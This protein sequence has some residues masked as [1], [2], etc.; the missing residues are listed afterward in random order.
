VVFL[1]GT[2]RGTLVQSCSYVVLAIL[3]LEFLHPGGT[4][5]GSVAQFA[6]YAAILG[7]VFWVGRVALTA[8]TVERLFLVLWAFYTASAA[9]GVLQAYFPGQFQPPLSS[10]VAELGRGQVQSLEIQL[11]SGEH[12]FR[13]MG[14]TDMPGGAAYGAVYAVLLGLGVLQSRKPFA[15]ARFLAIASMLLGMMCLYLCQVR[16]ALIM[17][18]ICVL[19]LVALTAMSGRLSRFLVLACVVSIAVPLALAFAV[20]LGGHSV[21]DRLATLTEGDPG[22]IYYTNR[23]RFLEYTIDV[24]LPKYP[25][26]AGLG[27]WGMIN[28]YFGSRA[29]SIYVEIQWTAWLLDGGV[30]MVLAY[31]A[32]MFATSWR[33]FRIALNRGTLSVWPSIVVAYNVGALALCFSY[34]EFIGTSGLEFW[35]LN[36]AVL[37]AADQGAFLEEPASSL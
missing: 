34:V 19:A 9:L 2:R 22:S 29:D 23:G 16:A 11:A 14:L 27:R 24:L 28:R 32:L 15:G 26:G 8:R 6:L 37:A 5:M 30:A 31:L 10:V 36:A 21:T 7:P 3:A 18:G 35:L 12:I 20:S 25:L 13:P 17:L 4:L 33:C 1:R